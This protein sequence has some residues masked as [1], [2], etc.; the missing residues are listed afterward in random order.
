MQTPKALSVGKKFLSARKW[1][2]ATSLA[3]LLALSGTG[4][5]MSVQQ[6]SAQ[7]S[8]AVGAPASFADL[9][10]AVKPAVVSISVEGSQQVRRLGSEN[11]DFQFP[12]LPPDHPLRR[13]FDRF[14]RG[15][16]PQNGQPRTRRF[17][18]A[19]AGFIIS[20]DGLVVTNNH[21][22]ENA[23]NINITDDEG[24]EHVATLI[25]TDRRTD[26][27][28][29]RIEGA[30]DLPFVEFAETETR[31]GDWVVAVGNPFGLG[32]TVTAGIVS[33]RGRD[34]SSNS[35]GDFIQ[36][37]AAINGGNSGGP[38]F[39]LSGQVVGVN[40]AIFSPNGGN[41]G[42]AFAIPAA[43]VKQV[44][45]DLMDDG[46]V[47]RG[48]LGVGIQEVTR[49]I[50][51]SV[52]L[53]RARGAMVTAPTPDGPAGKAGIVAGDIILKVNGELIDDTLDLIRTVAKLAPGTPVEVVVWR[54]GREIS[55]QVV[56]V[57]RI[58][59]DTRPGPTQIEEQPEPVLPEPTSV[60]LLLVENENGAGLM[61]EAV[62]AGSSAAEKNFVPGDIILEADGIALSSAKQFEDIVDAVR[63]SG[64]STLLIK[65]SRGDQV[66]YL[67]LPL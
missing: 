8:V 25:G 13:F 67:G 56:L 34:I 40:T 35:Y 32:G 52:G 63:E 19:G 24:N 59:E 53:N 29:L 46:L 30:S 48:F 55:Y 5:L 11:F 54:G 51:D 58:E 20:A 39:N 65:A 16:G 12:D 28:L 26:L 6:S 15:N 50:A 49:D 23:D 36:I 22:V 7:I 38:T 9:V 62:E 4:I 2:T 18:A 66:R 14:E 31:V 10:E 27:A 43:T 41:V 44:I 61:V 42:I 60:G 21:V 1:L 17:Q 37:D 33:A 47:S 57:E 3:A 64:R 45:T